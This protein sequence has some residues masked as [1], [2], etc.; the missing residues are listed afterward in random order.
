MIDLYEGILGIF[1]EAQSFAPHRLSAEDSYQIL[2]RTGRNSGISKARR[3]AR[4]RERR[5]RK[6]E[7][8]R[9]VREAYEQSEAGRQKDRERGRRY[10]ATDKAREKAA[11]RARQYRKRKKGL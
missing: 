4:I 8:G 9:K 2:V 6:S 5:Y 11:T 3:L 1:V 7:H 10:R